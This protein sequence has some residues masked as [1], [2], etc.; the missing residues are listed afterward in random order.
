MTH[1]RIY[2]IIE[3]IYRIRKNIYLI[4]MKQRSVNITADYNLESLFSLYTLPRGS[5]FNFPGYTIHV[6]ALK[7]ARQGRESTRLNIFLFFPSPLN[8]IILSILA[9][10]LKIVLVIPLSHHYC[11][12]NDSDKIPTK[13]RKKGKKKSNF[14]S[15]ERENINRYTTNDDDPIGYWILSGLKEEY[16]VNS[17][18]LIRFFK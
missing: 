6:S 7:R 1:Q 12:I 2:E 3:R 11:F 9:S 16:S 5:I 14:N 13:K 4:I 15:L 18:R 8:K 10:I 17:H